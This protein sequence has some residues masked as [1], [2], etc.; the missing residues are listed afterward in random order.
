MHDGHVYVG[1]EA[2][3]RLNLDEVWFMVTPHSPHKD[4]LAYAPLEHRTH[5]A[6]LA[7]MSTGRLGSQF[8]VSDFEAPLFTFGA[9]NS[10]VNML[11]HFTELYQSLQ[12]VWLM[13]SDC[14]ETL[15]TWGHYEEI[16]EQYP[17]AIMSR[18]ASLSE[19]FRTKAGLQFRERYVP[20]ADFRSV[21]GT[22]TFIDGLHH[23]VSSTQIRME[24]SLGQN[25]EGLSPEAIA[26]I[27]DFALFGS[28]VAQ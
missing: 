25:P 2:L 23:T 1:E 19:M 17:V 24:M 9:E 13:G 20:E 11:R 7:L 18:D 28:Q 6:H 3:T 27:H 16:I 5:L 14:F 12:P 10:T 26:Y 4:P 15:H 8:K 21:A 22:W